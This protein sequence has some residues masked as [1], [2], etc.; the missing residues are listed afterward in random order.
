ME[1]ELVGEEKRRV[2]SWLC[3]MAVRSE[4]A[5]MDA[6]VVYKRVVLVRPGGVRRTVLWGR[7][8]ANRHATK[9][10]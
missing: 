3:A 7:V 1:L 5:W 9:K 10:I 2:V 4:W 6:H 8:V